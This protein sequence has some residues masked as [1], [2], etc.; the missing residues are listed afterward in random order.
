M[1]VKF[2]LVSHGFHYYFSYSDCPS[3]RETWRR[4]AV[5]NISSLPSLVR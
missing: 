5:I 2:T 4:V 3:E 1:I